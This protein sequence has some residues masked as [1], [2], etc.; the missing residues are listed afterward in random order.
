MEENELKALVSLLEDD[1]QQI[2]LHVEDKIRSLGNEI[3]PYL[4]KAWEENFNPVVQKRLEE[5][6]HELQFSLLKHRLQA[7]R[8]SPEQDLLTG[9][10]L[11]ATYQYPD[12]DLEKLRQELEQ[13]YYEA[14]LELKPQNHPYDQVKILNSVVFGKLKFSGNTKN[15]HSPANSMINIVLDTRKGNPISLCVV[16]MLIAQKLKMPVFGVNLPNLF[17]LTYKDPNYTQFYINA[18][19][20]GLIFS[21][22]DIDNYIAELRLNPEEMFYQPC[23]HSDILA[24]VLRNLINSFEKLGE[25]DKTEEVKVLLYTLTGGPGMDAGMD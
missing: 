10:W 5:L 4:E 13:L 20:R 1:D 9:M 2:V 14:W 6:I 3:I 24:R 21:K 22:E 8:D 12:L 25:H 18:F 7:W 19:N 11:I 16:Y 17:I 23:S 15:F